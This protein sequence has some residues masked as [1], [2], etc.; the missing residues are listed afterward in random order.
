MDLMVTRGF[1]WGQPTY[2]GITLENNVFAHSTNGSDPRWH[3]YGFLIHGE[4][5]QLT[6]ARIV[7]NTFETPTGGVETQYINNASGVWAN[8]I[9]GGWD[10]LPGMTYA[11]NVG[12][13]CGA[14]DIAVS[15]SSSCAPPACPSASTAAVGWLNPAQFDFSLKAGSPAIGAASPAYAPE[16]DRRGYRRD[17]DPDAG[18]YEYGAVP[19]S[20]APPSNPPGGSAPGARWKLRRARLL[21]KTICHVPRRGCPAS[22]KLRLRLGR[23]ARVT[24]RL[25]RLRKGA[26]PKLVRSLP[27]RR[28]KLH[29]ALRIRAAGLASGRYRVLVRATDATGKRSALVRLRLRVR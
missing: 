1:W 20:G 21:A 2:G 18:A 13:K 27:L 9:G 16:R 14:S 17:G 11:G 25:Q 3:Y 19:D 5:G 15:P 6:N 22:T 26:R 10:C 29:K 12:T 23:P 24:V 8:N 4:M 28:V 7:N